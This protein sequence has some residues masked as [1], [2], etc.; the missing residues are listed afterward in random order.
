M[1]N[2]NKTTAAILSASLFLAACG[3][4]GGD[5]GDSGG[6]TPPPAGSAL[7][8]GAGSPTGAEGN[9]SATTSGVNWDALMTETCPKLSDYNLF[10]DAS[11]PT[12]APTGGG[13]PYDLSTALFSDY[14]SKY[15]FVFVPE[16][17]T[18]GYNTSEA[19]AACRTCT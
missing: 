12:A 10:A 16:G 13:V 6:G 18:V 11:D 8:A 9:C 5:G 1:R 19:L 4:G 17:K 2:K 7:N 15:R 3:G 14:T